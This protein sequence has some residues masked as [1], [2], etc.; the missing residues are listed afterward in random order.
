M[1][2]VAHVLGSLLQTAAHHRCISHARVGCV[3]SN[4]L[5]Y[6]FRECLGSGPVTMGVA[7]AVFGIFLILIF[8]FDIGG[9]DEDG[10]GMN[11]KIKIIQTH[12]QVHA[13]AAGAWCVSRLHGCARP[14]ARQRC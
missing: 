5:L 6:W 8:I 10:P 1:H 14:S 13:H 3:K 11:S 2:N 9:E 12:F 4:I 7:V